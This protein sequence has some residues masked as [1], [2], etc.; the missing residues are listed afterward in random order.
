MIITDEDNNENAND[1]MTR[2]RFACQNG[3]YKLTG[4]CENTPF[5]LLSS[6]CRAIIQYQFQSL[7]NFEIGVGWGK[8]NSWWGHWLPAPPPR[9]RPCIV[10]L[11]STSIYIYEY[12]MYSKYM[13]N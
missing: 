11:Y 7:T 4:Q 5:H 10:L 2:E 6:Y 1:L 8:R 9:L 3:H 12:F 13:L